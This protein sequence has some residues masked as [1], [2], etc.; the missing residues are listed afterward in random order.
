MK[1]IYI[2]TDYQNRFGSKYNAKPYES[3]MDKSL[4]KKYFANNN[5]EASFVP[6]ADVLN[7]DSSHWMNK[8]VIYTSSEDIGYFYKSY[9]EDIVFYLEINSANVIPSYKFL[10][11]NNNKVFM[12]LL[13]YSLSNVLSNGITT[14]AYGCFEELQSRAS[15]LSYPVVYKQAAGAQSDGVGMARNYR[16]LIKDVK[17]IARTKNIFREFWEL[18]RSVKYPG[19][20]E[21]SKYR[22][23]F[24]IQNLIKGLNGDFKVLVFGD[25]FYVLKRDTKKNDFRAS[26]SGIRIFIKEIPEGLLDFANKC[27]LT[28]NIPNASLD[29]AF[30]G[31]SFYLLEFQ[32]LYFGSFTLTHSKFYWQKT[33]DGNFVLKESESI[34]EEEYATSVSEF[35]L[36]QGF[37]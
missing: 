29:I 5:F 7:F 23:K 26:G 1:K 4:L 35:C 19:Y 33:S 25:K 21:Q 24:I 31:D 34:L 8:T 20:V 14:K 18:G 28:L 9:I 3:G 2:L 6:F 13:R 16:E 22:N 37:A 36:K 11:A 27:H 12:E 10:R 15:T 30:D 32:C 17:K